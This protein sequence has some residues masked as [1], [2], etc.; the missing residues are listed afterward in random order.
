L[1]YLNKATK[2]TPTLKAAWGSLKSDYLKSAAESMVLA[3]HKR[4]RDRKEELKEAPKK[5]SRTFI[6]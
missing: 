4:R 1:K 3:G 2:D 5:L 6:K